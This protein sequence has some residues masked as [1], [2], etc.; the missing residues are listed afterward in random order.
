MAASAQA[1]RAPTPLRARQPRP[2]SLPHSPSSHDK[3]L[4]FGSCNSRDHTNFGLNAPTCACK[5][6]WR[7]PHRPE[8]GGGDGDVEYPWCICGHHACFHDAPDTAASRSHHQ[9]I[10]PT[11]HSPVDLVQVSN[12]WYVDRTRLDLTTHDIQHTPRRRGQFTRSLSGDTT[13]EDGELAVARTRPANATS[14]LSRNDNSDL[15]ISGFPSVPSICYPT[16][17]RAVHSGADTNR[18]V[19]YQPPQQPP[20]FDLEMQ[21]TTERPDQTRRAET[22]ALKE[23]HKTLERARGQS[24]LAST[25]RYSTDGES[26]RPRNSPSRAFLDHVLQSRRAAAQAE[27]PS[28]AVKREDPTQNAMDLATS[29]IVDTQDVQTYDQHLHE[30]TSLIDNVVRGIASVENASLGPEENELALSPTQPNTSQRSSRHAGDRTPDARA[31]SVAA[32][33]MSVP[34]ALRKLAPQLLSLKRHLAAQPNISTTI[35]NMSDRLWMLENASFQHVPAEEICDKFDLMDGRLL[36]V[37]QRLIDL[38]RPQ[39]DSQTSMVR[40]DATEDKSFYG[41]CSESLAKIEHRLQDLECSVPSTSYPWEIEV[42]L[43]PWGRDLH[44]I[45]FTKSELSAKSQRSRSNRGSSISPPRIKGTEHGRTS[46]HHQN[47]HDGL[48]YEKLFPKACGPR[49]K[50]WHRLKSRGF[51]K[52]V[53]ITEPGARHILTTIDEAF[54]ESILE[55]A[56]DSSHIED[57]ELYP[58]GLTAPVIPLRKVQKDMQLRFLPASEMISP[59]LWNA[60]FLACDVIHHVRGKKRLYVTGSC[61]YIQPDAEE[62]GSTWQDIKDLPRVDMYSSA[63]EDAQA[64]ESG[65]EGD[66]WDWHPSLDPPLETVSSCNTPNNSGSANS[67]FDSA[68][69]LPLRHPT[70]ELPDPTPIWEF[71]DQERS[72][73]PQTDAAPRS[74]RPFNRTMPAPTTQVQITK[75]ASKRRAGSSFDEVPPPY[76]SKE[77]K[78][79][80]WIAEDYRKKRRRHTSRSSGSAGD[81]AGGDARDGLLPT[82]RHSIEPTPRVS[83]LGSQG[84]LRFPVDSPPAGVSGNQAQCSAKARNPYGSPC[85]GPVGISNEP[86]SYTDRQCHDTEPDDFEDESHSDGDND[87]DGTCDDD[88]NNNNNSMVRYDGKE[89][90]KGEKRPTKGM[91]GDDEMTDEWQG[92]ISEV[93]Q[94]DCVQRPD[95]PS[96][97]RER[98]SPTRNPWINSVPSQ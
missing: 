72:S 45:W 89:R 57:D 91:D 69:S 12:G 61:A 34:W 80:D 24:Q 22:D 7:D 13:A 11:P 8:D 59:T 53:V 14:G 33:P 70:N 17:R 5:R 36:E 19:D 41:E 28:T 46:H 95:S 18:P 40:R 16:P 39:E 74:P 29:S 81:S 55:V 44:G 62:C 92:C 83:Y 78:E 3:T 42:V 85:S 67:S 94:V 98:D 77:A 20:R 52:N 1:P 10:R 35:Q 58:G 97:K 82:P 73:S 30:T 54:G 86:P 31:D 32:V 6:F 27:A 48:E 68:T 71:S 49:N 90:L 2:P 25:V 64:P 43:L 75:L 23:W 65:Y 60:E 79:P 96:V 38:D 15:H 63:D 66:W 51:V 4:P 76:P 47:H 88:D 50:V 21:S 87:K 37:E 93:S 9:S 56:G 26:D 84:S